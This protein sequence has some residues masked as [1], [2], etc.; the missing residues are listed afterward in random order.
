MKSLLEYQQKIREM[1]TEKLLDELIKYHYWKD[2]V[3]LLKL[4]ILSRTEG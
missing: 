4:E 2:K 3:L 1:E